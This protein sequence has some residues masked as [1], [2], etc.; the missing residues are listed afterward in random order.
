MRV[1][2]T[3]ASGFL[4]AHILDTLLQHG[5][6][7]VATVRSQA[8]ADRLRQT[9]QKISEDMLNFVLVE[10]VARSDAFDKAVVSDP[11][12]DAVIHTASPF[13]YNVKDIQTELLDPAMKGTIGILTS[14]K[15]FAPSVKTVVITSSF[16]AIVNPSKGLWPEHTYSE[17]DWN[18]MS[19]EDALSH[20]AKGYTASKAFA[21]KAAWNFMEIEKPSFTLTTIMPP[22]IFGPIAGTVSS[23]DSLNTSNTLTRDCM[24]GR[25]K[26]EIPAFGGH[27]CQPPRCCSSTP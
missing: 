26:D 7:V 22:L 23:L 17:A 14:I 8:K 3:G 4:A 2:L 24:L 15:K 1:L 12:F 27:V 19:L 11:P 10:D 5:H 21:E 16:A 20:P 13:H 25:W 6:A 18:P 9:R